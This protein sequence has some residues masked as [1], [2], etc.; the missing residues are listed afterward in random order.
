M[1]VMLPFGRHVRMGY[2]PAGTP[3]Y[4]GHALLAVMAECDLFRADADIADRAKAPACAAPD[5][6]VG[7]EV[8]GPGGE[9]ILDPEPSVKGPGHSR[10]V[11]QFQDPLFPRRF[12]VPYFTGDPARESF[13]PTEQPS[14]Y[15]FGESAETDYVAP[16]QYDLET[17]YRVLRFGLQYL[18]EICDGKYIIAAAAG[19]DKRFL[20]GMQMEA[21][22][23]LRHDLGRVAETGRETEPDP[24]VFCGNRTIAAKC[25]QGDNFRNG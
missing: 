3:L 24:F 12:V 18:A 17:L 8:F 11:F 15:R 6:I 13:G 22:P 1:A 21:L 5:T 16:R 4:T 7:S 10:R 9:N 19:H 2:R 20:M 23:D 14:L 25:Q